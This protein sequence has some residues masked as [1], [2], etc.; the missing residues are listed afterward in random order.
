M[1]L[2]ARAYKTDWT[3]S[4]VATAVY[5]LQ[6]V[7]PTFTPDGGTYSSP[8]NVSISCATP[9]AV[10]RYTTNGVDPTES[11]PVVT[12]PV[13]VDRSMILKAR[14]YKTDWLASDIKSAVYLI[15]SLAEVK[16]Q[17]NGTSVFCG[18]ALVSGTF[19]GL[20]Y[21]E[22]D[23]CTCGIR[24]QLSGHTLSAGMRADVSGL[25]KTNSYGERYIEATTG[26]QSAPPNNTGSVDP[27]L[28]IN[29]EVGGGNWEYDAVTG[30]GQ[31][32]VKGNSSLNNMGLLITTMGRVTY[33]PVG[34]YFVISDGSKL[35][36]PSG[37]QGVR[38]MWTG[39]KPSVGQYVKVTGISSIFKSGTDYY[40]FT[41]V[42]TQ[43]DIVVVQ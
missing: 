21:V 9:G 34:S 14:A 10:V 27:L 19:S 2:K 6:V 38:I 40:P 32:G 37:Y 26:V 30:S 39:T 25:M 15:G 36:D 8:Q 12:G 16:K 22:S 28:L 31:I 1:I 13:L 29:R 11:D 18:R 23:D 42:R 3:P 7:T 41:R 17:A 20:F 4:S 33:S 43:A 24:V 35:T 5:T